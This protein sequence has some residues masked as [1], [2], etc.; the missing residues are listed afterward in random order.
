MLQEKW[1]TY[2]VQRSTDV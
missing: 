1:T 2:Y